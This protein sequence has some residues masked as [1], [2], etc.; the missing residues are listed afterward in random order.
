MPTSSLTGGRCGS[1][2]SASPS[3][4]VPIPFDQAHKVD[5]WPPGS[6]RDSPTTKP[7]VVYVRD[8]LECRPFEKVC[9]A[10]YRPMRSRVQYGG[11]HCAWAAA[12][13]IMLDMMAVS[14]Y[15]RVPF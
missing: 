3:V 8:V 13:R 6:W 1:K 7:E 10:S 14:P 4:T 2:G 9:R 15:R 12:E 11:V 5:A